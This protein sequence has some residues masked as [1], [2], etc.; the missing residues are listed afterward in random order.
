MMADVNG[1]GKADIVGFKDDKVYVSLN[2]GSSFKQQE[3]C[4][5]DFT[6]DDGWSPENYPI[7]MGDING[8]KKDD[9]VGFKN[10]KVYV[11]LSNGSCF[12]TPR[13]FAFY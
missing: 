8:D 12:G 5:D 1:D 4:F 10:D 3:V 9:I 6:F 7:A 2:N 11:S 13:I